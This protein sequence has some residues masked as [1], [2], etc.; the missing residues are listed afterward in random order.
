LAGP[1][2]ASGIGPV[3]RP[4]S[5]VGITPGGPPN[6]VEPGDKANKEKSPE[7]GEP[8]KDANNPFAPMVKI[9]Q[10]GN[11]VSLASEIIAAGVNPFFSRMPR[12]IQTET[13]SSDGSQPTDSAQGAAPPPPPA[14]PLD[15]VKLLGI[16]YSVK[17]PIAL[18][19]VNG[20][21]QTSQLVKM[22]DVLDLGEGRATVAH[23]TQTSIEIQLLGSKKE[24]RTLPIPDI[25]GYGASKTKAD[26][27]E[28]ADAGS[29]QSA[30][31]KSP[32]SAAS[33]SSKAGGDAGP[34]S[35]LKKL[36]ENLSGGADSGPGRGSSAKAPTVVLT[37]P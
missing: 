20:A 23:I 14:D 4:T 9:E 2:M 31:D 8:N 32:D 19:S 16:V 18:V 6:S 29:G 3:Q 15:S 5:P 22:G 21:I 13:V 33:A 25:V 36:A 17:T 7:S 10:A 37:E 28:S 24:K 34:L 27:P 12:P 35:N 26:S 1:K 11:I 30:T